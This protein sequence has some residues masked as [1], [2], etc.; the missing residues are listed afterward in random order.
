MSKR[1]LGP[2]PALH[3]CCCALVAIKH[4]NTTFGQ[5][6]CPK[7]KAAK[8]CSSRKGESMAEVIDLE[9]VCLLHSPINF[10]RTRPD[11]LARETYQDD[12]VVVLSDHE[13]DNLYAANGHQVA[14]RKRSRLVSDNDIIDLVGLDFAPLR[15]QVDEFSKYTYFILLTVWINMTSSVATFAVLQ[16]QG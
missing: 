9:S 15:R 14:S 7:G 2:V 8:S 11:R 10:K 12:E 13:P 4:D 3:F 6:Q 16:T 1:D 5:A